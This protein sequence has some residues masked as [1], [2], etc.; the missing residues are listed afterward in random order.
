MQMTTCVLATELELEKKVMSR[1][2]GK[3]SRKEK[4]LVNPRGFFEAEGENRIL[5]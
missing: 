2:R 5:I 3:K 1:K 4:K